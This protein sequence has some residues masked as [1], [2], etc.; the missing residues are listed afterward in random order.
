L[1]S[2]DGVTLLNDVQLRLRGVTSLAPHRGDSVFLVS[3]P[4]LT[5]P[6]DLSQPV[7]HI[8]DVRAGRITR[9]FFPPAIQLH[10]APAWVTVAGGTLTK[11]HDRLI[12]TQPLVDTIWVFTP[13]YNHPTLRI[14]LRSEHLSSLRPIPDPYAD[15]QAFDTWLR[16]TRYV[17][18]AL[19][20]GSDGLIVSVFA[21]DREP[22]LLY[23]SRAGELAQE[24]RPSP[25]LV[26]FNAETGEF[27]FQEPGVLEPNRLRL[28]RVRER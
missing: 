3:F 6:D 20:A 24:I 19:P 27:A 13:P 2:A 5:R 9:S 17:G 23:V 11:D 22:V 15:R 21:F 1:W 8:A 4:Q 16:S 10:E 18:S 14:P 28:A 26:G 7:L 12:V 25:R